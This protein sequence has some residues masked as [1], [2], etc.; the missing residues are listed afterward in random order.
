MLTKAGDLVDVAHIYPSSMRNLTAPD[1]LP[2]NSIWAILLN[3]WSHDRVAAWYRAIFYSG[4]GT[5]VVYN[6][7]NLAP[8]AHKYHV[9]G[10][11]ALEPKK[12]SEDKKRLTAKLFWLPRYSYSAKVDILHTP[13]IPEHSDGGIR[14]G[15]IMS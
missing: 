1:P 12:I 11:F 5:E 3:F 6:L 2:L 15:C 14:R 9:R 4:S 7:M 13:S 10:F 8:S